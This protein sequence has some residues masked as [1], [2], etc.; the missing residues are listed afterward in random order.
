MSVASIMCEV[1]KACESRSLRLTPTR[2]RVLEL[3]T[4]ADG[5]V[6]AYELLE[7]LSKEDKQNK[8]RTAPPTV[9]RALEFLLDNHFIHRLETLNAFV[10]CV[11]PDEDH[12]GQFLICQQC[13]AVVEVPG[14]SLSSEVLAAAD[15]HGFAAS[16]QVVEVYGKCNNCQLA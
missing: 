6:K 2:R 15:K 13:D 5:P 12:N 1:E 16:K 9:Y 8:R 3:I 10:S 14:D 11:H 7:L 4:N